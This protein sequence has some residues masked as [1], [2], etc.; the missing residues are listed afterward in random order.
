M[1]LGLYYLSILTAGRAGRRHGLPRHGEVHH[2]LERRSVT[3]HSKITPACR[4]DEPKA[5]LV[6]RSTT[7]RLAVCSGELL[8][9]HANGAVRHLNQLLTKKEHLRVID[10]VY[11]HCGQKETVMFCDRIMALG[12]Y[13][14]FKAGISF[15]KDDMV[16]PDDK[17]DRRRHRSDGE[18][19]R[20]AVQGRPDYPGRKVQQ[21]G[22]RLGERLGQGRR[23][24]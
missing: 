16:M 22:R 4:D 15:G 24:T 3:L 18:G 17:E 19:L 2:A 13:N 9:K 7:P 23:S 14:A 8:P 12:F 20:A 6:R 10:Q 5:S 11:R 21:G 1:V